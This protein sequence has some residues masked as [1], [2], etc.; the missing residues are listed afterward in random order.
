MNIGLI[1]CVVIIATVVLFIWRWRQNRQIQNLAEYL[2]KVNT[3]SP[4]AI[5][6]NQEGEISKLQDE[7]YKTVT[8]LYETRDEALKARRRYADNLYNIAHQLKT[9]ITSMSL[10]LQMMREQMETQVLEQQ[11]SRLSRLEESLLLLARVDSGTLPLEKKETDVFTLLMM[12]SDNLYEFLGQ[13]K[14]SVDIPE[15]GAARIYA[16]ME[17]TMEAVMNLLK[18]CGE[19][20]PEG[21]VIHCYYEQNPI[22]TQISIWDEGEGFPPQDIPHLFERFYRGEHEKGEGIGI[23][24]SLA[25]EMIE[26]Q[27]GTI[28]AF[29][30]PEGGACFEIHFYCH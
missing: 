20:S 16:D 24:L 13:K 18:N 11:L 28:N 14:I 1:V 12:V 29:N 4:E 27:D 10:S 8:S 30:R 23:G 15:L 7:I 5:L 22:Y 21:G 17:W 26:L 6:A 2:E 25:K 19:H 9:P 3:G